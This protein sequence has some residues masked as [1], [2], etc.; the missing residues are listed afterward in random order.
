MVTPASNGALTHFKRA[1]FSLLQFACPF[2]Q[3]M[4]MAQWPRRARAAV[5]AALCRAR[6]NEALSPKR[7]SGS[8]AGKVRDEG[9]KRPSSGGSARKNCLW[10]GLCDDEKLRAELP[11]K[12]VAITPKEAPHQKKKRL[13]KQQKQAAM[14]RKHKMKQQKDQ[15]L[16]ANRLAFEQPRKSGHKSGPS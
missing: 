2:G 5:K 1:A 6:S 15:R 12:G 8:H 4:P 16:A 3:M 11:G 7:A 13:D 9:N 10:R 14:K